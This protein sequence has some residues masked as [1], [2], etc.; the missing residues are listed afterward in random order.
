MTIEVMQLYNT[1]AEST[2]VAFDTGPKKI[3][4]DISR[5]NYLAAMFLAGKGEKQIIDQGPRIKDR[6]LLDER[7]VLNP[8]RPGVQREFSNPQT[9]DEHSIHWAYYVADL[10]WDETEIVHNTNVQG[11]T[12]SALMTYVKDVMYQKEQALYVNMMENFDDL[13]FAKPDVKL[14]EHLSAASGGEVPVMAPINFF[15]NEEENGLYSGYNDTNGD[16]TTIMGL[17]PTVKAGWNC[18]RLTYDNADANVGDMSVADNLVSQLELMNRRLKFQPPSMWQQ[19]YQKETPLAK[20]VHITGEIGCTRYRNARL[21]NGDKFR[22]DN[23]DNPWSLQVGGVPIIEYRELDSKELYDSGSNT[24]VT[25]ENATKDGARF[26][27][28][29][30]DYIWTKFY[31]DKMFKKGGVKEI[32]NTDG[33]FRQPVH[34][35]CQLWVKSLRRHGII[36]PKA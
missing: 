16:N 2:P 22:V 17:D 18:E 23:P 3:V 28:L 1:L 21:Q 36:S 6:I 8:T 13:F 34:L 29:N 30:L 11:M 15:I 10:R 27:S 19:Y 35:W 7:T 14:M 31:A 20:H 26:Y 32:A 4:E 24:L 9:G 25:A 33:A 12:K 5:N